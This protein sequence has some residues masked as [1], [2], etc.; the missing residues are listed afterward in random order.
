MCVG[1]A[2]T[3][4]VVRLEGADLGARAMLAV[5]PGAFEGGAIAL[6]TEGG[7]EIAIG[8]DRP[9]DEVARGRC[10]YGLALFAVTGQQPRSA[11][12]LQRRGEFPAEIHG[13][14]E[15]A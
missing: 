13:V 1:L 7:E 9:F 3:D 12:A 14:F 2:K 15:S 5:L 11:P 10:E 4:E 6:G 8:V